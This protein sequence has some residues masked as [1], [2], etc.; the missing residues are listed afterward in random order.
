MYSWLLMSLISGVFLG[1][2][3]IFRKKAL[4]IIPLLNVLTLYTFFSFLLVSF[5]IVN[6]LK[7]DKISLL[8][9][10]LKS[11]VI[12]FSWI[13]GFIAIRGLPISVI[14][15]FGTLTPVFTIILGIAVLGERM[16]PLQVAGIAVI[17]ASCYF[18]G[19]TGSN[20]VENLFRNKNLY[21]MAGGA[22]LSSFSAIIDKF[23][24]RSA[25][26]GQVQFWFCLFLTLLYFPAMVLVKKRENVKL[27]F[28]YS[29]YI[30]LMSIFLV[31][32]DRIY[33][34]AVNIPES[35]ISIILP[36]RMVSLFVSVII[37]GVI[38]NERN[39]KAKSLCV[40][41]LIVGIIL[42]FINK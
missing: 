11:G 34:T 22:I 10:L 40:L 39:I 9:V 27:T 23:A 29:W 5:D 2:Y 3:D 4:E 20:E 1:F 42:I 30:P 17:M 37:G 7:I 35:K 14:T 21:I 36:L 31:L 16:L 38:F 32:A 26:A 8:L 33:F 41:L 15:P 19:E 24:L 18:I 13:M 25:N 12:F 28:K 6:A